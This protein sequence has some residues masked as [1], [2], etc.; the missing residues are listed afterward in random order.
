[1][2]TM[3]LTRLGR[4][5]VL[6]FLLAGSL[7][8]AG[9]PGPQPTPPATGPGLTVAPTRLVFDSHKRTAQVDLTNAGNAPGSY[10]ISLVAMEMDENGGVVEQPLESAPGA[11]TL[12]N[13]VHFA[14]H[15]VTLKPQEGQTVRIQ[16]RRPADLPAGEYRV[17]LLVREERMPAPEEEAGPE[18]AKSLSI[19]LTSL[20]GVA[21]PLI[22]RQGETSATVQLT[23]LGLDPERKQLTLRLERTG[24][25]SVYGNLKAT[26]QPPSGPPQV[27]GEGNGLAV[28]TPNPFRNVTLP[29]NSSAPAGGR[30]RVTYSSPEDQ[31][32]H[33]LAEAF[34]NV[35]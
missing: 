1:M 27:L 4:E 15:L 14:P 6:S 29:L 19:R 32:G 33:L 26:W 24:N 28:Y 18:A 30:I 10:R 9:Q 7:P 23:R 21:I 35:P 5:L 3:T 13:L 25:Q 16:I 12:V 2:T 11:A 17:H 20:F 22:L 8:L 34:L 31:G